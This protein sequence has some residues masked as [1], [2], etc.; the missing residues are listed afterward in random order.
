MLSPGDMFVL[1]A[2]LNWRIFGRSS[3][4]TRH[5]CFIIASDE[6][7][8]G[9]RGRTYRATLL[10]DDRIISNCKIEEATLDEHNTVFIHRA[11]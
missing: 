8:F 2:N 9:T 4:V 1:P 7:S 5:M 10:V 11:M 3:D 6:L